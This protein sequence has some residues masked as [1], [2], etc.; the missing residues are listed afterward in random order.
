MD[1]RIV[2]FVSA[3]AVGRQVRYITGMRS[4]LESPTSSTADVEGT[5]VRVKNLRQRNNTHSCILNDRRDGATLAMAFT[6]FFQGP[7]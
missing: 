7:H 6:S 3:I 2:Q 1:H 4:V 5:L